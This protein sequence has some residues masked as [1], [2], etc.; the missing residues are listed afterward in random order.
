MHVFSAKE[1]GIFGHLLSA[2]DFDSGD[3]ISHK[4]GY[5]GLSDSTPTGL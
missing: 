5:K 3:M 1:N 4:C 2:T